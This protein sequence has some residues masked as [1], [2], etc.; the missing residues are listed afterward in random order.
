MGVGVGGSEMFTGTSY[1]YLVCHIC[2]CLEWPPQENQVGRHTTTLIWEGP[3]QSTVVRMGHPQV[4]RV[5]EFFSTL[6]GGLL[7]PLAVSVR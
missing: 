1:V 6:Q 3:C 7:K 2:E 5:E 4:G